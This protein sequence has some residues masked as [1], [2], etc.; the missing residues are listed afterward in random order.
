[1]PREVQVVTSILKWLKTVPNCQARK[2]HGSIYAHKGD[3]D[4]YGCIDGRMFLIEC[5]QPGENPTELQA[6]MLVKWGQA[7]AVVGVAR[8]LQ[9]AKDILTPLLPRAT[10]RP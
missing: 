10:I 1:M 4:I 8:S 5:K 9:D 6:A 7:G 2:L 3:P